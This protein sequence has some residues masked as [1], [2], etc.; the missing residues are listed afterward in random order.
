MV[1]NKYQVKSSDFWKYWNCYISTKY[2]ENVYLTDSNIMFCYVKQ[3]RI[4]GVYYQIIELK[5]EI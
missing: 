1:L 5:G 2:T 4:L 3:I